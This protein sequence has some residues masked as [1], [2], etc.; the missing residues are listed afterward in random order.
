MINLR[1]YF[2]SKYFNIEIFYKKNKIFKIPINSNSKFENKNYIT[3]LKEK[4]ISLT[5]PQR[6][7]LLFLS[8]CYKVNKPCIIQGKTCSGK[9][10]IIYLFSKIIGKHLNVFQM[11][12]DSG[13]FIINGQ[14]KTLTK[15]FK[16]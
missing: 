3:T 15:D 14:S 7:C 1:F 9:T 2:D 12:K 11:N 8:L 13:L 16:L 10:H 6:L 4:I 5:S